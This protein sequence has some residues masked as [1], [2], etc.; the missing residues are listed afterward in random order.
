M[1]KRVKDPLV[2]KILKAVSTTSIQYNVIEPNDKI[3]VAISGGKDSYALLYLLKKLQRRL[4]FNIELLAVHVNQSQPGFDPAP[5]EYWLEHCGVPYKIIKEDIFSIIL[6]NTKPGSSP[7][8]VCSRMRRGVLYTTA[9]KN[10]CNKIALGH[11]LEDTLATFMMNL[12]YSGRLQAMPPIYTTDDNRFKVVRPMIEVPVAD[13]TELVN[14]EDFPIVPCGSCSEQPL[15]KRTSM[16]Q[17]L[18]ELQKDNPNI[19]N[20]MLGALKHI[21]PTHLMDKTVTRNIK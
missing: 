16:E 1:K 20:V 12:F 18:N 14:R 3:L 17:M 7:C 19:K 10:G 2:D 13:I 4:P 8:P 15:H 9:E 21:N 11:H 6:N 5:L